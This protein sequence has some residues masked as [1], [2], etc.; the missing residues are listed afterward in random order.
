M[1]VARDFHASLDRELRHWTPLPIFRD[2]TRL[3]GGDFFNRELAL[4][5]CESACMVMI[6][7]PTYF[8]KDKTYCAREYK[9]MEI[10]ETRRL[11]QLG[12]ERNYQHGLIIPV[13]Y[14]GIDIFPTYV[15][16]VRNYYKFDRFHVYGKSYLR[17]NTYQDSIRQIAKYI[18]ERCNELNALDLDPC[19]ICGSF[20]LPSSEDVHGWLL[21][22]LPPSPVFPGRRS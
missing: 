10:L 21:P 8:D 7:T 20:E 6:Y 17:N 3:N 18:F 19:D 15:S 4:A 2:E 22:L 5:L 1:E 16:G 14:R 13:V 11:E 9:A 12:Y